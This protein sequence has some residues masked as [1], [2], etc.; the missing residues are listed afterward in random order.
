MPRFGVHQDISHGEM[1]RTGTDQTLTIDPCDLR[2]LY[3]GQDPNANDSYPGD[4]VS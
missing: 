3:E 1:T 4:S 2:Y